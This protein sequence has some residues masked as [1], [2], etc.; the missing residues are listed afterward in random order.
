MFI[1]VETITK[2]G[3]VH[4]GIL[5]RSSKD[6]KRALVWVHGLTGRFYGDVELMN[7]LADACDKEGMAFASFN[8]RGHDIIAGLRKVDPNEASGYK[9]VTMGAGME[10]FEECV[11]DIDAALT[12]LANQGFTQV[13]LA[14]HSTGANKVCYYAANVPDPRVIGVVLAG[15]MSDRLSKHT[16]KENYDNNL[17]VLKDLIDSGRGDALLTKTHWMPITAKRAWSL[18]SPN[19]KEDVFNYGDTKKILEEFKRISVPKLVV[20]SENDETADRPVADIRKVFDAHAGSTSYKSVMI[21]D[22]THGY[23]GK[24]DIFVSEV[25]SWVGSI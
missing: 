25:M 13:I 15:P 16:D 20:L 1:L 2:D 11:F 21:P 10:V 3:L 7:M 19:T 9:H 18:L 8:N 22:T 4:Q 12:F 23:D 6:T 5:S 17:A 24:K 14:G